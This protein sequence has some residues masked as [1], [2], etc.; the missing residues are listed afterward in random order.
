MSGMSANNAG[1]SHSARARSSCG[2]TAGGDPRAGLGVELAGPPVAI[3]NARSHIWAKQSRGLGACS[4]RYGISARGGNPIRCPNFVRVHPVARRTRS[5]SGAVRTQ[6]SR[7][8]RSRRAGPQ[9]RPKRRAASAC[10]NPQIA[11]IRP[12]NPLARVPELARSF[13]C[14]QSISFASEAKR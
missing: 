8:R 4:S 14:S 6:C 1:L 9:D 12:T 10:H 5:I 7:G 11:T 2:T 3:P 13:Q